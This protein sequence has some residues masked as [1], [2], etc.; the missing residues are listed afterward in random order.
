MDD[1]KCLHQKWLLHHFHPL[2]IGW[3]SGLEFHYRPFQHRLHSLTSQSNFA[4]L[5]C[6]L[7]ICRS[8]AFGW[9]NHAMHLHLLP[10]HGDPNVSIREIWYHHPTHKV[11]EIEWR[12]PWKAY[13][14]ISWKPQLSVENNMKYCWWKK[15]CTSWGWQLIPFLGFSKSI[16]SCCVGFLNHQ[17]YENQNVDLGAILSLGLA[18]GFFAPNLDPLGE[19]GSCDTSS[20][21][22]GV[23]PKIGVWFYPNNGW[24][25]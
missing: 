5:K 8:A 11:I 1:S 3:L 2:N 6:S 18:D 13:W 17:L 16:P 23:E 4:M 10:H 20:D 24:W 25:K 21:H 15:S 14:K 7:E 12:N 19:E 9:S 22:M